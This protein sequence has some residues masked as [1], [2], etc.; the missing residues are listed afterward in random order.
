MEPMII[1]GGKGVGVSSWQ[2]AN[3]VA[4]HGQL[5][6]VSG[7]ALD[8]VL[9]RRLQQ[10]DPGGHL[11]R[12]LQHFPVPAMARR[13]LDHYWIPG[14]KADAAAFKAKPIPTARV[15]S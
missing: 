3:A 14:G 13:A 2:L 8:T 5:G 7:T 15:I 11:R 10:G 9:A 4:R 6:V 12:A 1:Q